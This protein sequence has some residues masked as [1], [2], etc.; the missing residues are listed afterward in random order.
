MLPRWFLKPA[1]LCHIL[2]TIIPLFPSHPPHQPRPLPRTEK[3]PQ[4]VPASAE[5]TVRYNDDATEGE[6]SGETTLTQAQKKDTIWFKNK[7]FH[8]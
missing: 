8:T 3:H 4:P 1:Y 6:E 7:L 2:K 5:N